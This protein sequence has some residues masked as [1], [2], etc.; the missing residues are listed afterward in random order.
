LTPSAAEGVR[1][2]VLTGQGFAISS[3]SMFA[4]ELAS[5]DVVPVL[6]DWNQPPMDLLVI[7]PSGR[8]TSAKARAFVKW[9]EQIIGPAT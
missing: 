9:F 6:K 1:E 7:Y 4:P 3:R 2:A 8:L 5:G